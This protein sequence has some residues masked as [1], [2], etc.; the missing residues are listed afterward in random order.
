MSLL[1]DLILDLI[2]SQ[3]RHMYTWVQLATVQE[4]RVFKVQ[5]IK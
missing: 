1:Q 2:L 5:Y 3:K 4:L